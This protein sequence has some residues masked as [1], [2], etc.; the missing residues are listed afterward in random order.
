MDGIIP[1]PYVPPG[2]VIV[3]QD[4][5]LVVVDKPSGLLSVP[6]RTPENQD[7]VVVRFQA[8]F[9]GCPDFPAAHRLD[10]DT[11]GLLVM[12]RSARAMRRMSALFHDRQ[13]K[14][15]YVALLDG[16]LEADEGEVDLSLRLD[17][18]NRPYQ[19]VDFEQGRKAV[20]RWRKLGI[21]AGR[22]RVQFEP[23]TGRT[24]Q[25]RV[26]SAHPDGLG[27]PIVGDRLY[28]AGTEPG[29]LKLHAGY[30]RFEHPYTHEP[31]EFF[32]PEP[33]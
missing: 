4:D 15:R 27:L 25:L 22:T 20:T 28:G 19:V 14:K 17:P 8:M 18:D 30:L 7:C 1:N 32:T 9:P 21:K 33:F 13:V 10:M 3:H 5:Y 2:L 12:A 23:L 26:H 29:Q 24:H 6:G 11:S 31:V 16:V